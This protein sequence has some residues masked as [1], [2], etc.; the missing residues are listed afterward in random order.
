MKPYVLAFGI[1]ALAA[2]SN[3]ADESTTKGEPTISSG[4]TVTVLDSAQ[5]LPVENFTL[6]FTTEGGAQGGLDQTQITI[7]YTVA[8]WQRF[9]SFA[10]ETEIKNGK[11]T[12]Y[13]QALVS[14]SINL[15]IVCQAFSFENKAF[16]VAGHFSNEDITLVQLQGGAPIAMNDDIYKIAPS[17][18][19]KIV[20]TSPLCP[21]GM[22]CIT[23][24]T[25]IHLEAELDSCV[26]DLGPVSYAFEKTA[27]GFDL[28]VAVSTLHSK[29]RLVALCTEGPWTKATT[30]QLPMI[31]VEQ[32]AIK[33]KEVKLPALKI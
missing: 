12:I 25:I 14:Q 3:Q 4:K 1:A 32:A 26:D 5:L 27:N 28:V 13:T 15:G 21:E 6:P 11:L 17:S 9:E 10:Y 22:V 33:L 2:C 16:I 30:I 18:N 31:F 29:R 7:E 23:D 19:V 20:S 8:C 24:G